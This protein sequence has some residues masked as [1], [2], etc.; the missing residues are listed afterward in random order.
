MVKKRE[1][2]KSKRKYK[3]SIS[4][5]KISKS[6]R[7]EF[8]L[9]NSSTAYAGF[10]STPWPTSEHRPFADLYRKLRYIWVAKRLQMWDSYICN[11]TRFIHGI[12][13]ASDCPNKMRN[14]HRC[15]QKRRTIKKLNISSARSL[16]SM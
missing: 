8:S 3:S 1:Y 14:R 15:F 10:L 11:M 9:K 4:K 16:T 6:L 5:Y 2:I 12:L 13:S 7:K